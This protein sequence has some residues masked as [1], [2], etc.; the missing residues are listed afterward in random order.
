MRPE[1]VSA[2]SVVLNIMLKLS[3]VKHFTQRPLPSAWRGIEVDILAEF[4]G[5]S[6]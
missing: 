5:K 6:T 3:V 1:T 4:A 2:A